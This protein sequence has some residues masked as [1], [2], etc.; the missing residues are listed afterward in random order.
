MTELADRVPVSRYL[1]VDE[2]AE[3]LNV[4]VRFMRRLVADHRVQYYKVGKFLRFEREDLDQYVHAGVVRPAE[5]DLATRVWLSRRS[6][7]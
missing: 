7:G 6:L 5:D 1:T 4:T 3:Y 2:A